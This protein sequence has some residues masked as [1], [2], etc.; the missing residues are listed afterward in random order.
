MMEVEGVA[1]RI[2]LHPW[3]PWWYGGLAAVLRA[4][5]SHRPRPSLLVKEGE[6]QWARR[7]SG[8]YKLK[9]DDQAHKKKKCPGH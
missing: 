4:A 9:Q 5:S 6:I 7:A 3:P 8:Q 2:E 1:P